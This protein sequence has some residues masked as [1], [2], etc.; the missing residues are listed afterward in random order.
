MLRRL[1][2]TARLLTA[3]PAAVRWAEVN[4]VTGQVLVAFEEGRVNVGGLL[5]TV[6]GVEEAQG[7]R[8]ENFSWS[9]PVHPGDPTPVAAATVELAADCLSV[10]T[11][12]GARMMRLPR[13]PR[14]LRVA[15]A[16]LEL[17]PPVRRRLKHRSGPL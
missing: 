5:E 16:L 10:A 7:T 8:E 11:A 13:V 17:R 1:I 15:Q 9:R 6:R 3:G 14:A 2:D 12:L 4:A